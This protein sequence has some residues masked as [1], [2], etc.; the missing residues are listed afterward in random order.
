M[1]TVYLYQNV[2]VSSLAYLNKYRSWHCL[3][4]SSARCECLYYTDLLGGYSNVLPYGMVTFGVNGGDDFVFD[5][6]CA[7]MLCQS[8]IS[9][10]VDGL[11]FG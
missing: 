3:V 11:Q 5:V 2:E 1:S 8:Q 9:D 10:F 4:V 6:N 7:E